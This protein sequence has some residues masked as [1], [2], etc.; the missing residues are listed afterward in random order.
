LSERFTAH[1]M[2]PSPG[3]EAV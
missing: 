3:H 1:K 2:R